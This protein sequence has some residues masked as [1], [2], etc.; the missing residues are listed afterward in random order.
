[1]SIQQVAQQD[2]LAD[3]RLPEDDQDAS[4]SFARLLH[5]G[6]ELRTFPLTAV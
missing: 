1:M 4:G 3:A 6:D 5:E 2:R